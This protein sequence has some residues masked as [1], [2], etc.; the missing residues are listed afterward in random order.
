MEAVVDVRWVAVF[1]WEIKAAK[2][3]RELNLKITRLLA[4]HTH[5]QQEAQL[6]QRDLV[7]RCVSKL[8]LCFTNYGSYKGFKQQKWPSRSFKS[9]DNCASR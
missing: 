4:K 5:I 1:L 2:L 9:T 3:V 8:V 7:A 6:P